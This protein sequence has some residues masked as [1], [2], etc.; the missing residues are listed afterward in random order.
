M[1][2]EEQEDGEVNR[3]T[4]VT[5]FAGSGVVKKPVCLQGEGFL[6]GRGRGT[7]LG[8]FLRLQSGDPICL[9][10][11]LSFEVSNPCQDVNSIRVQPR[12]SSVMLQSHVGPSGFLTAVWVTPPSSMLMARTP[13]V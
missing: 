9:A 8:Q 2:L 4:A 12:T 11:A 10:W 6:L 3:R 1:T 13:L 7:E 5:M